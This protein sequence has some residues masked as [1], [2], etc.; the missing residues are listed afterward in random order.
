MEHKKAKG[1][2]AL[3]ALLFLLFLCIPSSTA[4]EVSAGITG[5][6]TDPTGA[7]VAGANVTAKDVN[8]G[9]VWP[10]TTNDEGIYGFP[11]IPVGTY[12][13]RI[14]ARGFKSLVRPG[15]EL[16]LNQRARLDLTLGAY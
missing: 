5:R 3:T 14:A 6:I 9:T 13:L 16:G 11:R 15:I 8:R 4:R 7:A 12:E 10:A 1:G 2:V